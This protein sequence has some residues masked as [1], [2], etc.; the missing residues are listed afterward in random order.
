VACCTAVALTSLSNCN[1]GPLASRVTVEPLCQQAS[2]CGAL[3]PALSMQLGPVGLRL[4]LGL[5]VH[6]SGWHHPRGIM[7]SWCVSAK[8]HFL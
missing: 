6:F 2:S 8:G 7:V 1:S 3:V 4:R 5:M